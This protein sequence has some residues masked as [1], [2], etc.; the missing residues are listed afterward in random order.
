MITLT[1]C[2]WCE[3]QNHEVVELHSYKE[4]FEFYVKNAEKGCIFNVKDDGDTKQK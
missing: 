3:W 2:K 4:F 1:F